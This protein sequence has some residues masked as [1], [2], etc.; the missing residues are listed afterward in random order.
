MVDGFECGADVPLYLLSDEC[1]ERWQKIITSIHIASSE[2]FF[3]A[4]SAPERTE[5]IAITNEYC[6]QFAYQ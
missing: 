1:D 3:G 6:G 2:E 5:H 4:T